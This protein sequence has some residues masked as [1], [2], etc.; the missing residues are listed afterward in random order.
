[1]A[2]MKVCSEPGCPVLS[3]N[4]R[5]DQHTRERQRAR[6]TSHDRGYG[7]AHQ[8]ERQ[9]ISSAGIE[10]FRCARCG[11]PFE[12]GEPFQLGHTDDRKAW[13]GPEH[14]R[15]NLSAAGQAS[16]ATFNRLP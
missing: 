5:C 7:I 10:N 8:R 12:Q 13:S 14:L 3:E 4:Q 6:G 9:R 15:C 11:V 1:M 2:R 16:H